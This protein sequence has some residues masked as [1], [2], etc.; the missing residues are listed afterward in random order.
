MQRAVE[1]EFFGTHTWYPAAS[2][3]GVAIEVAKIR[4][5]TLVR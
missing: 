4:A 5:R 3:G 2:S 1:T